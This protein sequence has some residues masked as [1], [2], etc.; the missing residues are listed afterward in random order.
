[1]S[2]NYNI[3]LVKSRG[4]VP[5]RQ[6]IVCDGIDRVSGTP[7]DC[8]LQFNQPVQNIHSLRLECAVIPYSMYVVRGYIP[9]YESGQVGSLYKKVTLPLSAYDNTNIASA[10][11]TA[12][13][14]ASTVGNVYTAS[15]NTT[16]GKLTI[17]STG[18]FSLQWTTD[19]NSYQIL[20]D[21]SSTFNNGMYNKLGFNYINQTLNVPDPDTSLGP[22]TTSS[23]FC[24]FS[25]N[26]IYITCT[27]LGSSTITTGENSNVTYV[28]PVN[29][30]FGDYIIFTS[31]NAYIAD[32]YFGSKNIT[33]NNINVVLSYPAGDTIDL[34]GADPSYVFSYL[35]Y[36]T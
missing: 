11:A 18:S 36:E 30:N 8:N 15:F 17:N 20:P 9:L 22:S 2:Y 34:N 29:G 31:N 12:L 25:I 14:S 24:R 16:T 5:L 26:N 33:L 32:I 35:E 27:P 6:Y 4:G 10:V 19:Y 23:G 28:V 1:M 21:G 7:A 3:P 13:T